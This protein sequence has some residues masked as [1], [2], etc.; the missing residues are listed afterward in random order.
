MKLRSLVL[1][2]AQDHFR[3]FAERLDKISGGSVKVEVLAA[4]PPDSF[5]ANYYW[6]AEQKPAAKKAVK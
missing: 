2:A 6:P 3:I 1:A 5:A 4:E